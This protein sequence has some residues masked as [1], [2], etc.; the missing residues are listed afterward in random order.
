MTEPGF[1]KFKEAQESI[2]RNQ[3]RQAVQPGGPIRQPYYYSIIPAP[4]D[5]S[6]IP[7]QVG[8]KHCRGGWGGGRGKDDRKNILALL[9]QALVMIF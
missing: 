4:I 9:M 5:C 1:L 6:K 8:A 7:A 2:P 3:F